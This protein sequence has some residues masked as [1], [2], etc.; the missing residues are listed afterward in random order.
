MAHPR[1]YLVRHGETDWNAAGRLLSFTDAPLNAHGER[2]AADLASALA[3]IS[4][5]RAISSPLIRAR[6]TAE[7]VL[8]ASDG[9]PRLEI[10][11]RLREMDRVAA[12]VRPVGGDAPPRWCTATRGRA[13]GGG[14]G[15]RPPVPRLAG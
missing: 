11:D 2:R 14:G 12:R 8:A 10:D 3:T 9:A 4:W 5:D 13:R 6:R 1:L 7:L 15:A